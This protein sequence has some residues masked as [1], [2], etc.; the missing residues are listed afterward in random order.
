MG[1]FLFFN[2]TYTN[3]LPIIDASGQPSTPSKNGGNGQ[4]SWLYNYEHRVAKRAPPLSSIT[5]N[6]VVKGELE[7]YTKFWNENFQSLQFIRDNKVIQLPSQGMSNLTASLP[8]NTGRSHGVHNTSTWLDRGKWI[9]EPHYLLCWW[10][11][12]LWVWRYQRSSHSK[13]LVFFYLT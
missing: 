4:E 2:K 6:P 9:F 5:S 13:Y 7:K 1:A 12:Y 3:T 11:V 8:N 10:Y